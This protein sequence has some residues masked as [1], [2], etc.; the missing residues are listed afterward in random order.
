[1]KGTNDDYWAKL[2]PYENFIKRSNIKP[3]SQ[4]ISCQ[5]GAGTWKY[6]INRLKKKKKPL[7]K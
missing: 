3:T 2:P 5:V 6:P 1:M 7:R 4:A